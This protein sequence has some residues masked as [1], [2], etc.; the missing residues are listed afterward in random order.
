MSILFD[1]LNKGKSPIQVVEFAR[2]Y[3]EQKFW[4]II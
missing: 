3:L 4:D 1:L 2:E